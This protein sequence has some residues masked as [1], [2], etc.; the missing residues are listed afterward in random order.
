MTT[1]FVIFSHIPHHRALGLGS[2]TAGV[3]QARFPSYSTFTRKMGHENRPYTIRWAGNGNGR[4]NGRFWN[5]HAQ[6]TTHY[7]FQL[8][9]RSDAGMNHSYNTYGVY[10]AQCGHA[11]LS[12]YFVFCFL[13]PALRSKPLVQPLVKPSVHATAESRCFVHIRDNVPHDTRGSS[14]RVQI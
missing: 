13:Q 2:F 6:H 7:F 3:T 11:F 14:I 8:V 10:P 5:Y 1:T 4:R 12:Q 9:M